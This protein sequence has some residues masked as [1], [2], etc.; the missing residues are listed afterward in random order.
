MR[1]FFIFSVHFLLHF[2]RTNFNLKNLNN[3]ED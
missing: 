2:R 1:I 3:Y